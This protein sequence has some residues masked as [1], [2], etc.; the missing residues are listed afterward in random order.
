MPQEY[1]PA[2]EVENVARD[3]I[4]LYHE[5]L[6]TVRIDYVFA[7]E[8]LKEK[9]KIVWGRAKK[10]GGLNAWLAS[11]DQGY[12][13]ST[14]EEFFVIEI[15][16]GTWLQIDAKCRKALVD[17]ELHHLDVDL[18]TNKLS[19]RPHDLEEFTSIVRRY[20]LWH[21]DVEMFVRAARE[22][23]RGLFEEE[24]DDDRGYTKVTLEAGGKTY[25]I[26]D[27]VAAERSRR[28]KSI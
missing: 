17:H 22:K 16:R 4:H 1:S 13:A 2:P 21:A 5:H 20:G 3:L 25:D 15:H 24:D 10:V 11:K 26:T 18:D 6:A 23:E 9:G 14:P 28:E 27:R 7:T 8:A 19:I 12:D